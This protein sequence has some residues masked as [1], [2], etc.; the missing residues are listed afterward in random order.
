[1]SLKDTLEE[2]SIK[3]TIFS[4]GYTKI[5]LELAQQISLLNQ[6]VKSKKLQNS[7]ELIVLKFYKTYEKKF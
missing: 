3:I 2:V 6:E 4:K 1:M 7:I 5:N